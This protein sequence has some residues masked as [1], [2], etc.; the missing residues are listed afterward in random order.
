MT[1]LQFTQSLTFPTVTI[2]N[3]NRYRKS[4]INGTAF[5]EFLWSIYPLAGFGPQLHVNYNWSLLE[6]DPALQNRT[7]FEL[8]AAHQLEDT[9]LKCQFVN[10]DDKHECGRE[11]FTTVFTEHGV[12]YSFNNGLDN[13]LKA[14]STGSSTGLHMLINVQRIEYTIGPRTGIGITVILSE[15]GADITGENTALSIAPGVEALV[16]MPMDKYLFLKAPYQT[17][18]CTEGTSYY[19]VYSY[20]GCMNEKMSNEMAEKCNC[21]EIE[22]PGP[23]R[24]CTLQES[25]E[26][27]LPLKVSNALTNIDCNVPCNFTLYNPRVTYGH[28]PS[29][30]IIQRLSDMYGISEESVKDN[31]IDIMIFY[32]ELTYKEIQ[33]IPAMSVWSLFSSF[34]GLMGLCIGASVLTLAEFIDFSLSFVFRH[35]R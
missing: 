16:A 15:P 18:C 12:C 29:P 32:T 7:E 13:I 35:Y 3:K 17:N 28:F 34:G 2:C 33:L 8:T 6:N 27:A 14:T 22:L 1:S 10:S 20:H 9:I 24:T 5:E 30:S 25:V 21:K 4:V 26:C 31:F 11:N 23:V 19:P